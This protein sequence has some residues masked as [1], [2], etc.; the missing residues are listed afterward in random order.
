M[1]IELRLRLAVNLLIASIVIATI[2]YDVVEGWGLVDS[3]YFT[4]S[5]ATTVGY[6]D[7]VPTTMGSKLFTI[8]FMIVSTGL[9]LYSVALIAQKRIIFHLRRQEIEIQENSTKS[10]KAKRT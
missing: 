10:K 3:L 5:T 2:F 8:L 1:T 9:A 7:L 4:V 6:G